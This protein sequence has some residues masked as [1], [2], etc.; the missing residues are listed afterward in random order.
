MVRVTILHP[1]LGIGGA[2]RLI[3][4]A[5]VGLQD[6]GHS[7]RIFTNQY[8]RSHCFQETLDLGESYCLNAKFRVFLCQKYGNWS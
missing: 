8:S 2:E 7:V 1:D 4:D 3:V 5:A 6:R